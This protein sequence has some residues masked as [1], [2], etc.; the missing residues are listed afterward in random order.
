MTTQTVT[1][2]E[3]TISTN[4]SH[5]ME[6]RCSE[7]PPCNTCDFCRFSNA[8]D[9]PLPEEVYAKNILSLVRGPSRITFDAFDALAGVDSQHDLVK[10]SYASAWANARKHSQ[11]VIKGVVK[12]YDWT[13]TTAFDG[14]FD[15]S[16]KIS[17]T[18]ERIDIESLKVPEKILLHD[19]IHLYGDDFGDNGA[20]SLSVRVRVMPSSFFVLQR[21][22]LRVDRVLLRVFDTR[23]HHKFDS[24]YLLRECTFRECE[25][26]KLEEQL[27]VKESGPAARLLYRE[28][29]LPK[30][31]H[32]IPI[33]KEVFSKIELDDWG[34]QE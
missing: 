16:W 11:G 7:K 15:S 5:I 10:V 27:G 18:E 22:Y 14:S 2:G 8:Y 30:I 26:P 29:Q 9:M 13:Y 33:V 20:V 12:P 1:V 17:E 3:W 6:S 31:V 4:R 34:A 28:E 21:L 23:L 19:N 25:L 32:R 24:N